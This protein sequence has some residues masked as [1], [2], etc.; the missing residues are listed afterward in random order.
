MNTSRGRDSLKYVDVPGLGRVWYPVDIDDDTISKAN[1][2]FSAFKE[3][4]RQSNLRPAQTEVSMTCR[5]H[6]IGGTLDT[7]F[8]GDKL[9]IGDWKTSNSVYQD[10]LC[11]LAAYRHLWEIN[12][13]QPITG[14]FHLLRFSKTNGDFTHHFWGELG[15]AWEAFELMRKLYD[16][17]KILKER[18]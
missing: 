3:W 14:G 12:T 6:M 13:N 1:S 17:D 7:I 4:S 9:A 11:Q 15:A 10:H 16:Y 2:S 5:C 8:L 18:L